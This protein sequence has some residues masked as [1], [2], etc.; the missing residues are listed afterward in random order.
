MKSKHAATHHFLALR[1]RQTLQHVLWVCSQV[2]YTRTIAQL[3]ADFAWA[4]QLHK[5]PS[6][7]ARP[8]VERA[9]L[10]KEG[11]N[12]PMRAVLLT[13]QTAQLTAQSTRPH[14]ACITRNT[15]NRPTATTV[16]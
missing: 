12:H 9:L 3:L 14:F 11:S 16:P 6:G 1:D 4:G 15:A 8:M 10:Q 7:Y 5:R 2:L 13:I